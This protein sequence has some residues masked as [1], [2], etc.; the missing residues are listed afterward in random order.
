MTAVGSVDALR[1]TVAALQRG[2]EWIALDTLLGARPDDVRAHP[3]L[4]AMRGEA[5]LR[6]GRA[7]EARD[8]LSPVIQI[9]ER[10]GDRVLHRRALNLL[11]AAHLE[12]GELV[13]AHRTFEWLLDLA[14]QDGDDLL[15]ARATNNLG[16]I[17]NIRGD[18]E[19]ALAMYALA[20]A[21]YQRLGHT[22]GL[23]ESH[24]NMG[25]SFRQLGALERAD[26]H[27]RRAIDFAREA[28]S[29]RL[30]ALARLGR[31]EISLARGDAELAAA[32]ATRV[33]DAFGEIPDPIQQAGALRVLGMARMAA[34]SYGAAA[35]VLSESLRL[36][37]QCG[38]SLDQA[39][40]LRALAYLASAS[41]DPVRADVYAHAAMA[42]FE[43]LGAK[44]ECDLLSAWLTARQSP[45]S[46][47]T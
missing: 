24:H 22:N 13:A 30:E 5:L 18:R 19:R 4:I 32:T 31:A 42:I 38:S 2:G 40:T 26:E 45:G 41:G 16:I 25:I 33:A 8:W 15:V 14:R 21:A 29:I 11:G 9:I 17:A 27:E 47:L 39:E 36:A 1:S 3:D 6:G 10:R 23:A 44:E 46:D 28:A 37:R 7:R 35:G 20:V 43:R 12:L 34:Q